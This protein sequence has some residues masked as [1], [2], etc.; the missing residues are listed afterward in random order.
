MQKR[1]LSSGPIR[2]AEK[3]RNRRVGME[4]SVPGRGEKSD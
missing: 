1:R 4:D 2:L 3:Q